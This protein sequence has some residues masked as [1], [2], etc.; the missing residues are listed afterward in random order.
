[1]NHNNICTIDIPFTSKNNCKTIHK[2]IVYLCKKIYNN[3]NEPQEEYQNNN[4]YFQLCHDMTPLPIVVTQ[5]MWYKHDCAHKG[6]T[7]TVINK[8]PFLGKRHGVD[9]SACVYEQ[10]RTDISRKCSLFHQIKKLYSSA[11]YWL[12]T[13]LRGASLKLNHCN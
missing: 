11:K 13:P 3:I 12:S 10:C 8:M 1:M 7:R 6:A 4:I 5:V 2:L 9:Y